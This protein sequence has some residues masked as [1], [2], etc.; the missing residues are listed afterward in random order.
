MKKILL[1]AIACL[2]VSLGSCAKS[3]KAAMEQN[4]AADENS[5]VVVKTLPQGV[6]ADKIM[7]NI[8]AEFKGQVV[9]VDFWATWCPPCM[10]AM[11]SIDPIKD[12]YLEAEKPV[13]FVYVTGETSPL[14]D[15]KAAIPAIKGYHYRLSNDQY[16]ALLRNLG[17]RGIPTYYIIGMDGKR[18]YDNIA[19][20]GYPGDEVITAQIEDALNKK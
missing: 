20:G 5:G 1:M 16:S 14:N 12:K 3:A 8:A 10:A 4:S 15:W 18:S 2:A 19:T 9:V 6:A 13:A 11:K 17:I 7:D